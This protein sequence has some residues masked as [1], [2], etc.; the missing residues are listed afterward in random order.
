MTKYEWERELKR[1]ISALPKSEQAK[2]FDYYGEIFEDKIEAGMSESEIIRE[3]GNPY[4]VA[5]RIL[6]DFKAETPE[7]EG[8]GP[9][10]QE[11]E[12]KMPKKQADR[13]ADDRPIAPEEETEGRKATAGDTFSRFCVAAVLFVFVGIPA[14]IVL[15]CLAAAGIALFVSGFVMIVAGFADFIYFIVQIC[16][17]GV[18]GAYIAHLGIGIG[19][20]ALGFL[21][22]PLF[23]H[24]TKW[25]FKGCGKIFVWTGNFISAKRRKK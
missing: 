24:L 20:T 7:E 1:H 25:L 5:R 18:T 10:A 23:M 11:P 3:F 8:E 22:T 21:L 4:D 6:A 19:C 17:Y 16:T 14:L 15:L 9:E 2:I 13:I 12:R